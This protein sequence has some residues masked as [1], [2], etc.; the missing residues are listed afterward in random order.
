MIKQLKL[1]RTRVVSALLVFVLCAAGQIALAFTEQATWVSGDPPHTLVIA[2][3]GMPYSVMREMYRAG[4]FHEFF[5]PSRMVSTFPSMT[6]VAFSAI[7]ALRPPK[8]YQQVHYSYAR[9][10]LVGG[11]GKELMQPQEFEKRFHTQNYGRF[12]LLSLYVAS[13]TVARRE[14]RELVRRFRAS[15]S[16]PVFYGYIA[17]TDGIAHRHGREGL[18]KFMVFLEKNLADLQAEH[19]LRTGRDLNVVLF[20]DHGNTLKKGKL[21]AAK[22]ELKK[23]GY[24]YGRRLRNNR[25]A[26]SAVAGIVSYWALYT[27]LAMAPTL[28]R[29]L[30]DME[31]VNAVL[32]VVPAQS[33]DAMPGPVGVVNRLGEARIHF[34]AVRN[35]GRYE[36]VWG[37]PLGYME[38]MTRSRAQGLMS[39]D[40]Y[41]S[42]NSL[43]ALTVDHDYPD[44]I[45]RGYHCFYGSVQH[46]ATVVVS[47]GP[48]YEFSNAVVKGF[49]KVGERWGTHGSLHAADS[50]GVYMRTDR[51]SKDVGAEDMPYE[52]DLRYFQPQPG[53]RHRRAKEMA[54]AA[55]WPEA[56]AQEP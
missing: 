54:E 12:Y 48:G 55:F 10:R 11:L 19:R 18:W 39:A 38:V 36:V 8:G 3:D 56:F 7:F 41:V 26:V 27:D 21:I 9:N 42:Q 35:R 14:W 44:A 23:R 5:S 6:D 45:R 52:L 32:F 51:P 2:F 1:I 17:G 34:D 29:S 20:S 15:R 53:D 28:A 43:F 24:R 49:A 4:H 46:P 25:T 50:L 16:T 22:K 31:G 30:V 33:S 47:L 13:Y 37:D 40:G